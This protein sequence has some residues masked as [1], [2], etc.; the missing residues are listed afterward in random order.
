MK[1]L[2]FFLGVTRLDKIKN[3]STCGSTHV[4][5]LGN[6]LLESRLSCFGHVGR[7]KENYIGRKILQIQVPGKRRR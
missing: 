5:R 4:T 6:K 7:R 1:M 3:K 2:R